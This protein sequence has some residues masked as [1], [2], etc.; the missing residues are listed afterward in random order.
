MNPLY[1]VVQI[2]DVERLAASG[3]PKGMLME[4]AGR[5]A[6]GVALDLLPFDTPRAQV[7]VLAGP[8]N[9]GGD[10]FEVAANLA[11][12]GAHVSVV[13]IAP[14]GPTAAERDRA[15]E[16]ARASKA[17]FAD[18]AAA[19][20]AAADWDLVVDGLFG[21]GPRR[22][23]D[24]APGLLVDAVNTLACPVLALDVPSGLDADTGC[25]VGPQGRAVRASHTVTFIGDKPGLHTC[26]GRDHAGNIIVAGL[27]LAPTL[28]PAATMHL[29][30]PAFFA[31]QARTRRHNSHKGSYGNVFVLGGAPGMAGAP[32]LA[33]RAALHAGAGRVYLC[34]AG[35][36]LAVDAGQ[37]ELMCRAARDVDFTAGVTVAGP[38]LGGDEE[39]ARLLAGAVASHQPLLLDADAL[40]LLAA[41]ASLGLAV[42]QRTA[43][44]LATPHPLEAA[45]LLDTTIGA[46]QADRPAAARM[47][48]QRFNACVV[49]KGSGTVVAAP[50]GR[51]AINP[52]GNAGLATAGTGDVLAGLAGALLAQGWPAWE[53]ALAAVWLH[54]IAADMLVAEGTGPIGLTATELIAT[55]RV[56]LNRLVAQQAVPRAAQPSS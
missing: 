18:L 41:D 20:I 48:A 53:A 47:L 52:T 16:R 13:H 54:G 50:D 34:F 4:R 22:P 12:A 14:T 46:V 2:R 33:G 56:A 21:I 26:D 5:A 15:L 42:A 7:L 31:R 37:P 55:I 24:G 19:D 40:N 23:L 32:V 45:R 49:L 51:I 36:P 27:D 39:A 9:N 11:D 10:A 17:R 8:G 38:G 30:D 28:L 6:A 35:A 44:T 29:N 25:V 3:L 43:P 1:S